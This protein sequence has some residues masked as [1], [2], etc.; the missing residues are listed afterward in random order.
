MLKLLVK[1]SIK[2]NL[3]DLTRAKAFRIWSQKYSQKNRQTGCVKLKNFCTVK[4][5][6]SG[7]KNKLTERE[8]IF[9]IHTSDKNLVLR[10]H[11]ELKQ[12]NN[13][14]THNLIKNQQRS[15]KDICSAINKKMQM[16]PMM[17]HLFRSVRLAIRTMTLDKKCDQAVEKRDPCTLLVGMWISRAEMEKNV[18]VL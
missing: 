18:T 8:N 6:I 7:L 1:K 10:I 3:H 11:Q 4:Q 5:I 15:W 17:G 9:V 12:L 2:E 13:K 16:K 14:E